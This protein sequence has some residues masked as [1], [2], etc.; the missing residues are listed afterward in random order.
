MRTYNKSY[1]QYNT[2]ALHALI[3]HRERA[4]AVTLK[5]E[6]RSFVNAGISFIRFVQRS[7]FKLATDQTP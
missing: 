1:M 3:H 7:P 5:M 2:L 4:A 6:Y